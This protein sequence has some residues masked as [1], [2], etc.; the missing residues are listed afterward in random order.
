METLETLK[1]QHLATQG[2]VMERLMTAI[3]RRF[4]EYDGAIAEASQLLGTEAASSEPKPRIDGSTLPIRRSVRK[5]YRHSAANGIVI[6]GQCIQGVLTIMTK[7]R[8]VVLLAL[9]SLP[10]STPAYSQTPASKPNIVVVLTDDLDALLG[11]LDFTPNINRLLR[12]GGISFTR[13]FVTNSVC[14]P[15]RSTLLR[16][17][18]THSH[19][20]YTNS[21]PNGSFLKFVASGKDS[22]TSATW[23][24]NA[25][26]ATS[27]LGK[28]L[29]GYPGRNP[30][31]VPPGWSDWHVAGNG[32][33]E[34][35]YR[36]NENGITREFGAAPTDYLTDVLKSRALDFIRA[37][38]RAKRPFYLEIATFTELNPLPTGVVHG[39]LSAMWC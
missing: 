26:Y 32:Y 27:L 7:F 39:P 18:Y 38:A 23:L 14:C 16:G 30:D 36:L 6:N 13:A 15:S 19:E 3:A 33:G 17:Q 24:A 22:S 5:A 21:P 28:Y 10:G 9:L 31:Y 37:N 12:E 8:F 34:F 20:V 4:D 29:N 2:I 35:N 1:A 11:T 25:G